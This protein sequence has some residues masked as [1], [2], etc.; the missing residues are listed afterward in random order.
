MNIE[1]IIRECVKE[2]LG[3][4]LEEKLHTVLGNYFKKEPEKKYFT[5]KELSEYS[6]ISD[7]KLREWISTGK[8]PASQV[9]GK[10]IVDIKDFEKLLNKNKNLVK[11]S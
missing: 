3:N 10:I 8:L 1:Q 2:E 5:I 9:D 7:S 6:T 11:I 4:A